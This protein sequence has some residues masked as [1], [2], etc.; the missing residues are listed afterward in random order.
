[1]NIFTCT[2]SIHLS[3]TSPVGCHGAYVILLP[4][5]N[6]AEMNCLPWVFILLNL[7][8]GFSPSF[9]CLPICLLSA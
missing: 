6:I 5:K 2:E 7:C 1:M 9:F 3:E 4:A 8:F